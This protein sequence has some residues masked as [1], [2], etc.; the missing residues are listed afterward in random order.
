VGGEYIFNS[1]NS[2]NMYLVS[3][4]EDCKWC[5]FITVNPVKDCMD[6]TGWGNNANLIYESTSVG[7]NSSQ[8]RFCYECWPGSLNLE[9]CYYNISCKNNF[10]CVNLKRKQYCILNKEYSKDEFFKLKEKIIEDM[11]KNPYVDKLGRKFYYG[12]FFPLEFSEFAYNKSN[13]M[14]FFPK[15]KEEVLEEGFLWDDSKKSSTES[16]IKANELQGKIEETTDGILKESIECMTCRRAYNIAKG[17]LDL[18]RKLKLPLPHECPKCRES[19]RFE[20]MT[21][22]KLYDR[23]CDKCNNKVR[24][25]YE[26]NRPEIIYC[27]KCY[28][29]EVF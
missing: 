11:K 27:E 24:S 15:T 4:A 28:Q 26:N 29:Q 9:Y 19:K 8:V 23:K 1:K 16:T 3:G 14:R 25:P 6:Y 20:R 13:A 22:P 5:Q 2:H 21:M 7:E 17:E 10:G 18:L 12:E